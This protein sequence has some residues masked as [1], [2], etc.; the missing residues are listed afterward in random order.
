MLTQSFELL[1]H[2]LP[3]GLYVDTAEA[4]VGYDLNEVGFFETIR[5]NLVDVVGEVQQ[6]LLVGGVATIRVKG[7]VEE[8]VVKIKAFVGVVKRAVLA[9]LL[10]R[11]TLVF[12]YVAVAVKI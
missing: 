9:V 6:V 1:H 3:Y 10:L 4:P 12:T 5:H 2:L 7:E 8:G 11:I